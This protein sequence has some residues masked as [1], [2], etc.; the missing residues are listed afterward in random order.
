MNFSG[1]DDIIKEP[2]LPWR[3]SRKSKLTNAQLKNPLRNWSTFTKLI[4][5]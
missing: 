5:P 3:S 4:M 1:I 2:E